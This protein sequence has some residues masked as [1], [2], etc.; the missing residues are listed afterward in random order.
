VYYCDSESNAQAALSATSVSSIQSPGYVTTKTLTLSNTG[1]TSMTWSLLEGSTSLPATDHRSQAGSGTAG[2]L[3]RN[4][5]PDAVPS[6]GSTSAPLA[7]SAALTLTQSLSQTITDLNS[8]A[9]TDLNGFTSD[10]SYIRVFNLDDHGV[11]GSFAVS[12]VDIGI[13]Y[14]DDGG[15][16]GQPIEVYLY[17]LDGALSFANMTLIGSASYTITDQVL[18]IVNLPVSGVA[19]AHSQL[20]V[21]IYIPNGIADSH[22]FWPGSNAEGQT[23]PS[24]LASV[25]CLLTDPIDI[26][27]LG[28]PD[29][30]LV[31]NVYGNDQACTPLD[32]PWLSAAPAGGTILPDQSTDISVVFDS[33]SLTNGT[34]SGN[35]CV[36]TNDA[37]DPVLA[38]S[39]VLDVQQLH[40][41]IIMK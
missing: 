17:T 30:H 22:F 35:V 41:P 39:A 20:V 21:E 11:T 18:T 25:D 3:T 24:Y 12:S 7:P 19:P 4:P 27:D 6:L 33:T 10:N 16:T 14:A 37:D 32:Y 36:S 1:T 23:A 29:M 31:M 5:N 26:A 40:L 8:I 2:S 34:Y 9:C 13:E 28:F 38:V 15:G